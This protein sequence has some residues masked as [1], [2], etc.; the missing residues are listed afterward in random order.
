M[1]AN[2]QPQRP[3]LYEALKSLMCVFG[4]AIAVLYVLRGGKK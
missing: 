2:N 3:D 4:A 1:T